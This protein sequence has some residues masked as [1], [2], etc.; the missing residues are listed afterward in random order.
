MRSTLR[1]WWVLGEW[2]CPHHAHGSAGPGA[3]R[4]GR[5]MSSLRAQV[6]TAL[7]NAPSHDANGVAC[8]DLD[9]MTDAVLTVVREHIAALRYE[10]RYMIGGDSEMGDSSDWLRR[11]A[12][13]VD[14]LGGEES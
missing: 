3:P 9:A 1:P 6:W 13:L 7:N 12:V 4:L 14:L 8:P 5:A 2:H 10:S 11:N